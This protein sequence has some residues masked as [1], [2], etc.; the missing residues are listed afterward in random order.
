MIL[1]ELIDGL[2][3]KIDRAGAMVV[4]AELVTG[5]DYVIIY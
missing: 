5:G 4:G 2:V 1:R 3:T